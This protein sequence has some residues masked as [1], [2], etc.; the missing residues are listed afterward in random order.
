M[1]AFSAQ[2][3]LVLQREVPVK[4]SLSRNQVEIRL[5]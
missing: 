2:Q 1:I 3:K 5:N 4:K